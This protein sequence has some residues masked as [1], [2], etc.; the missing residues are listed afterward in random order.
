MTDSQEPPKNATVPD[1][2]PASELLQRYGITVDT[3]GA[4]YRDWNEHKVPKSVVEARYL[5]TRRFHGKLFSRLVLA[6][7]GIQ[8]ERTH[9][10]LDRIDELEQE[11]AYLRKML[12]SNGIR[13]DSDPHPA[14]DQLRLDLERDENRHCS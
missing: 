13:L 14:E 7:L 4:M 10:L 2:R 1:V 8:T 6:Y 12:D 11:V 9:P 3:L 5:R